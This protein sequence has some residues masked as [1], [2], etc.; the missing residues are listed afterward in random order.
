MT[1]SMPPEWAPH[2]RCV[3][4][5]PCRASM[6][7][8]QLDEAKA[9]HAAVVEAVGRFEPVLLVARPGDG[10]EAAAACPDAEVVEWPLDDS[11]ARDIGAIVLTGDGRR[12]GLDPVFNGWG[13]KFAS[14]AEDARFAERMCAHLG[15]ERLDASPFVLEGGAITVDGDGSVITTEQCLLNPNRNPGLDRGQIEAE[16]Q[17]WLG[18]ERVVWLPYGLVEDVDTDGHVDNVAL[19]VG[20]GRVL[21]QTVADPEDVN[22]GRLRRNVE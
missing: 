16:L 17:R 6:W 5:W 10:D 19:C 4:A 3:V 15:L 20:P 8:D 14:Y 2:E 1:L 18:V 11:W 12:A 22:H 9:A 21:A 13:G 7:G